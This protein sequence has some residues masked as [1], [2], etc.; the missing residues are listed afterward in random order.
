MKFK[1]KWLFAFVP[2]LVCA[3]PAKIDPN[4]ITPELKAKMEDVA[5]IKIDKAVAFFENL[6]TRVEK[7]DSVGVAKLVGYPIRINLGGKGMKL[8][9]SKQFLARYSEIINDNV[10]N[11]V[12][13][14]KFDSLFVNSQGVMFGNGQIWIASVCKD[15]GCKA[16]EVKI[17]AINQ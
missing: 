12:R 4:A 10:K 15:K 3:A 11:A 5:G 2:A 1:M 6:V 14:Q 7:N 13:T 8:K 9:T 17:T 16:S